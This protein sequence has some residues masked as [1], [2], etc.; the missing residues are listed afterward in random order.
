LT[1]LNNSSIRVSTSH[2]SGTL[3]YLHISEY[4]KLCPKYPKNAREARTGAVNT[5][6]AGQVVFVESTAKG[7]KG[8]FYQLCDEALAPAG[9]PRALRPGA[10]LR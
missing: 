4:G 8:H 5:V 7:Q 9:S 1:L 3:N 2:P 6:E 10:T